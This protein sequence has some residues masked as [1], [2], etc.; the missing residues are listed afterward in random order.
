MEKIV[1]I[2]CGWLGF[3]LAQSLIRN[4]FKVIGTSTSVEKKS[5][6]IENNIEFQ[7]LD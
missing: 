7:Y 1:I 3:P 2:G 6:F 4:K 5:L